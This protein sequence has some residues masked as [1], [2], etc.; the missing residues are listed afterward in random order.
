M[1]CAQIKDRTVDYLY[2]ELPAEERAAFDQHLG[3]C[4]ACRAEV[5]GLQGTLQQARA[6]VKMTDEPPPARVRVAVLEAARAAAGSMQVA[7]RVA[8]A[9]GRTEA[10]AEGGGFWEWL[11]RPWLMPLAGAAAVVAIFVVANGVI[12]RPTAIDLTRSVPSAAPVA[13][14]V[15]APP[16]EPPAAA[17]RSEAKAAPPREGKPPSRAVVPARRASPTSAHVERRA[18]EMDNLRRAD[19]EYAPPPPPRPAL[20]Q[21]KNV[22]DD[23]RL[24]GLRPGGAGARDR[25]KADQPASGAG[26]GYLGGLKSEGAAEKKQAPAERG[27]SREQATAPAREPESPAASPA[28][29]AA[30]AA[31]PPPAPRASSG[32][33]APAV[34]PASARPPLAASAPASADLDERAPPAKSKAKKASGQSALEEKVEKADLLFTAGRW[35]E[36]ATA[37]REL[38]R[39]YPAYK[40]VPLWK[41]R[42]RACEQALGR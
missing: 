21:D 19:R 29:P 11:R 38:L 23:D 3:G 39:L 14:P 27:P 35:G 13:E 6:A 24:E 15:L 26:A 31:A 10:Q 9:R 12:T 4:D 30:K 18:N 5:A 25:G 37:Y 22:Y 16:A 42:L 33:R 36:A 1:T 28:P 34:A 2:G 32:S 7:A 17:Q 41:G 40:G 20:G 8:P